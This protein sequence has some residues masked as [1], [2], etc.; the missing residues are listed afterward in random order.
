MARCG[1][2]L[3]GL[4]STPVR[5]ASTEAEIVG[6]ASTDLDTEEL[7]RLAVGQLVEVPGDL[8]APP[9]YRRRVGV[10]TLTRALD[11]AIAEARGG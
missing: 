10:A 5:A 8:H 3:L 6:R 1:I 2:G 11:A 4:G 9:E 7:A